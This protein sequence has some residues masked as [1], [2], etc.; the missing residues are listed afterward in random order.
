MPDRYVVVAGDVL[1]VSYPDRAVLGTV[2]AEIDYPWQVVMISDSVLLV[3]ERGPVG[4][5]PT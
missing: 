1:M 5:G 2:E 4:E 3:L